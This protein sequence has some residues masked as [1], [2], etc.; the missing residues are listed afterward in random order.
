MLHSIRLSHRSTFPPASLNVMHLTLFVPDLLWPDLTHDAA[1]DFPG[2]ETLARVL[3][4][5]EPKHQPLGKTASWESRLA[6]LFGFPDHG[7]QPPPPLAALRNLGNGLPASGPWLCTDPVNLDFMQQALILSPTP[8]DTLSDADVTALLQSLN[9]EFA[10]EG[11]FSASSNADN[12]CH[13]SF[14]P[15]PGNAA[16]PDLT[17]CSRLAGRRVDADETRE[18]LDRNGLVW[19][20]RIQM[21]L[22]Q[23]PVNHRREA[24]GLA[25]INSLWPWGLGQLAPEAVPPQRF[26]TAYG[27]SALLKGLCQVTQTPRGEGTVGFTPTSGQHLVT[28]LTTTH[29]VSQDDLPAWQSAITHLVRDWIMPALTSLTDTRG[30]L[31]SLTLISPDAHQERCWTLHQGHPAL[32]GN[33]LQR[34]LGVTPKTPALA[35]LVR[36]WST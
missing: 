3:S 20:N 15:Q 19:I 5:A 16:L 36:S 30:P 34:W 2:C 27:K 29:A 24:Q 1:F 23:H 22:S 13:W 21:C 32:R 35:T 33:L 25:P 31:Q 14:T 6:A 4:L 9:E 26:N 8:A 11:R 7:D 18:L 17:A 28:A 12:T 10:G